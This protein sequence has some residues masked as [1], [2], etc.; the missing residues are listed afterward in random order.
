MKFSIL[1]LAFLL[2]WGAVLAQQQVTPTEEVSGK[3][4]HQH[5]AAA[6]QAASKARP[7]RSLSFDEK[8][9]KR[10]AHFDTAGRTIFASV[11]DLIYDYE[12]PAGIEHADRD[13]VT[14]PVSLKFHN[15][16]L[17]GILDAIIQQD[18]EL[19]VS[20][21]DGLVSIFSPK[22]RQDSSAMLNKVIK[23]F[24]AGGQDAVEAGFAVFCASHDSRATFSLASP[25]R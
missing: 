6:H 4:A 10:I 13:S 15:E 9:E 24:D 21:T 19:R 22:A 8:L 25:S 14:R 20:F 16:S 17:R 12:L 5:Q 1:S 2:G 7:T 3:V 23:D 18:P 11:L